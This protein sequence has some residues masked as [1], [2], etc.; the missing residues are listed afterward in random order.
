MTQRIDQLLDSLRSDEPPDLAIERSPNRSDVKVGSDPIGWV[1]ERRE[2]LVVYVPADARQALQM[3]Y[4]QARPDPA[5]L[6]FDLRHD[7]DAAAGFDLLRR[8]A[9]IERRGWQYRERSP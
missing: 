3:E 8:R 9:T 2:M 7:D 5:G 4:P 6:A 1:D